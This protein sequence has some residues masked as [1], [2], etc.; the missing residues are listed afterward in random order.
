MI[1]FRDNAI[2]FCI[3]VVLCQC[4]CSLDLLLARYTR[5]LC[6]FF[7]FLGLIRILSFSNDFLSRLDFIFILITLA[8]CR[9]RTLFIPDLCSYFSLR[10][11]L[12]NNIFLGLASWLSNFRRI[13]YLINK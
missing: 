1:I 8:I 3:T 12:I 9:T 13:E 4:F 7:P 10:I 2:V 6:R 5:I 11:L